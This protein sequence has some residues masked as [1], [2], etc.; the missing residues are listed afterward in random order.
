M[1]TST[2]DPVK[3]VQDVI[4]PLHTGTLGIKYICCNTKAFF[5]FQRQVARAAG[6][7]P[8]NGRALILKFAKIVLFYM[9]TMILHKTLVELN[10]TNRKLAN[11]KYYPTQPFIDC[12]QDDPRTIDSM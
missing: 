10:I 6:T 4:P 7:T 8:Y 11:K 9:L 3:P 1:A 2:M 5:F 12:K